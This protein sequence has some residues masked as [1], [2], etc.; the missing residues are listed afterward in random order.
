MKKMIN[1]KAKRLITSAIGAVMCLTFVSSSAFGETIRDNSNIVS[2]PNAV[3]VDTIDNDIYIN[4]VDCRIAGEKWIVANY[5]EGTVIR[6]IIPIKSFDG[7]IIDYCIDFSTEGE[8]AGYLVIDA[9]RYADNHI[10]EFAFD[11][12]G[13]YDTLYENVSLNARVATFDEKVIYTTS[14]YQYAVKFTDGC[15]TM[16]YSSAAGLLSFDDAVSIWDTDVFSNC[17]ETTVEYSTFSDKK[18]VR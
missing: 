17:E 1:I 6:D 2:T 9:R 16:V 13:I 7:L 11:G 15:H 4:V 3:L 10:V 12:S 5:P 18:K 14:P 8:P